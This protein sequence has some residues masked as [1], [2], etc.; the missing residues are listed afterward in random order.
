MIK[1]RV[2]HDGERMCRWLDSL[3]DDGWAVAGYRLG[4]WTFERCTP[5]EYRYAADFRDRM[6]SVSG[7]YRECMEKNGSE[8]FTGFVSWVLVKKRVS[9]GPIRLYSDPAASKLRLRKLLRF[10]RTVF[11][12]DLI[13]C[14]VCC[15]AATRDETPILMLCLA[16]AAG[17]LAVAFASRCFALRES[18]Y[19]LRTESSAA[20]VTRRAI[21]RHF[22]LFQVFGLILVLSGMLLNV[23]PRMLVLSNVLAVAGLVLSILGAVGLIRGRL[24]TS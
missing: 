21:P 23:D 19:R 7:K 6:L 13:L 8:I 24:H 15:I 17:L 9:D 2:F 20:S 22:L 11:I 16:A 3:S 1:F 10:F 5:G 12:I 18:V 4:I 14:G